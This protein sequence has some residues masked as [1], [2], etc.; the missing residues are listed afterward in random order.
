MNTC[1][2]VCF[3]L[4]LGVNSKEF[5]QEELVEMV[6]LKTN[7]WM[8]EK[9][10]KMDMDN[11]HTIMDAKFIEIPEGTLTIHRELG[12]F[13]GTNKIASS[14]PKFFDARERWPKCPSIGTIR[15][16]SNC[17]SCW[18]VSTASMASDRMCINAPHY[19][20]MLSAEDLLTCCGTQC[21]T[22]GGCTSGW[23]IN[24][25][26]WWVTNGLVTGSGYDE[27]Q[28][29]RPYS[30]Y[31]CGCHHG[32]IYY[33]VAGAF[34]GTHAVK[35]IGWGV[36]NNTPYWLVANSWNSDWGEKGLFRIRRGNNECGI[37]EAVVAALP[38]S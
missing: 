22:Y 25:L 31:P 27:R 33:H 23:P 28:G 24:A 2:F 32:G 8:A 6:M 38:A 7:L 37:E 35:I 15:D 14:A 10:E 5:L 29:C 21:S 11:R 36:E 17:G 12:A 16:Q 30:I 34:K 3:G 4:I 20:L 13:N 1:L 18:A 9:N 26:N 19:S